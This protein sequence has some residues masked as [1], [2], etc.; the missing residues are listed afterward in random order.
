[1]NQPTGANANATLG[2]V[3]PADATW[4]QMLAKVATEF[5]NLRVLT[6]GKIAY[7]QATAEERLAKLAAVGQ[8]T[9]TDAFAVKVRACITQM[10]A[11]HGISVGVCVDG[12]RRPF[13]RQYELLQR[14]PRVTRAGPGESNHNFGMATDIGFAGLRWLH[15]DGVVDSNETSWLH[16]LDRAHPA[17][18]TRF[19]DVLRAVGTSGAVGAFR[20]PLADRPHLQNWN[21]ANISMRARLAAHLQASGTMIWSHSD[22]GYRCDLGLGGD[23]Y[24]VGTAAQIWTREAT[25]TA[26]NIT[27]ARAAAA[28]RAPQ[29]PG[30]RAPAA[31]AVTA[32]D[33]TAMRELLRGEFD[34]ADANWQNWTPE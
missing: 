18:A 16:H 32:A 17:E 23:Q 5:V 27:Q 26:A 3:K 7:V 33:V 22:A 9:F 21:D 4:T 11:L 24:A 15:S 10:Q 13:Q 30:T 14:V 2:Q 1:V 6:G 19:W 20:G 25:V 31:A 29:R 8:L 28:T 12:D 34:L